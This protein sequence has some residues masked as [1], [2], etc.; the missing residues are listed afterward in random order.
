MKLKKIPALLCP[1][2]LS[3]SMLIICM[4]LAASTAR[5]GLTNSDKL[6]AAAQRDK[7]ELADDL[8]EDTCVF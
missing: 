3:L 5:S 8:S 4:I 7:K 2:H 1:G 6:I